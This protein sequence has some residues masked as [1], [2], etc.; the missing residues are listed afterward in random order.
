MSIHFGQIARHPIVTY[1]RDGKRQ[2]VTVFQPKTGCETE[3]VTATITPAGLRQTKVHAAF[4]PAFQ[5]PSQLNLS[6]SPPEQI[7]ITDWQ[8]K[9]NQPTKPATGALILPGLTPVHF[10]TDENGSVLNAHLSNNPW[11]VALPPQYREKIANTFRLLEQG[12]AI[13]SSQFIAVG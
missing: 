9:E 8:P 4:I 2:I 1:S 5:S 3:V 10:E 6:S 13:S 7:V 11:P 12:K